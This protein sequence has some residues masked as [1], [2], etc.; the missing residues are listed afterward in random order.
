[1]KVQTA[2]LFGSILTAV[3][4]GVLILT[5]A[6]T[7]AF[8]YLDPGAGSMMLQAMLAGLAGSIFALRQYRGRLTSFLRRKPRRRDQTDNIAG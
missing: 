3:L 4:G 5:S 2:L 6:T 7:P 1:M 8:A